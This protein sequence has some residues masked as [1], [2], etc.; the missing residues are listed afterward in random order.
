MYPSIEM[1]NYTSCMHGLDA[2]DVMNVLA[3]GVT[4]AMDYDK[5]K[6]L[7]EILTAKITPDTKVALGMNHDEILQ[8]IDPVM[9]NSKFRL[10]NIDHHH[11]LGYY[12]DDITIEKILNSPYDLGN[13]AFKCL[14]HPNCQLYQWIGNPNSNKK[15][16]TAL[17][18]YLEN[19][20]FTLNTSDV[21]NT[22]FDYIFICSS[23]PWIPKQYHPLFDSL[24]LMVE[25]YIKK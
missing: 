4:F 5:Y 3:P 21:D 2:W 24:E 9:D 11:D 10:Y 16:A 7:F 8:F 12:G 13:W 18:L 23:L 19:Y 20:M 1:Y 25:K 17:D 15:I 6:Q 14:S 22:T